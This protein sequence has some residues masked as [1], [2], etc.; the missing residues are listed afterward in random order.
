MSAPLNM[1]RPETGRTRPIIVS[2]NVD[3]PAPLGPIT[4]CTVVGI[5][6]RL[7][8]SSALKP[9]KGDRDVFD[10]E[11]RVAHFKFLAPRLAA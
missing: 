8:L 1:T 6:D 2:I 10:L 3:L 4:I 11:Q 7:T 9:V 5:T